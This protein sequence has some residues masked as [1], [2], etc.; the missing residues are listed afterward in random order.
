V[1]IS[2]LIITKDEERNIADCL[3]SLP[4]ADEI[5]VVD[6]GSADRTEEICRR[7]SRVRWFSEPWKGFGPQKNSALDK[8]NNAWVFSIDADERVGPELAKEISTLDLEGA[9]V[10]G[11][12]IPRKSFFGKR[13]VRHG[14]WYPDHTI[15]LWR[16]A[17][18]R[19]ADRSVHEVVRVEG[20]LSTLRGDLL[21][22]TYM[23]TA[24]FVERMNR[25]STL[26]AGELRKQGVRCTLPD[27]LFRPPFTFFRM[28]V[29]RRGF[30]D[31]AL[32]FRL[33]VLYAMY[34][35]LKYAKLRED[36]GR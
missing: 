5:V 4:F 12:R 25:Y 20:A 19:F 30:L 15:R 2:A 27:L 21:H 32:G 18:G 13:W 14:G 24:D 7:D 34:T 3:A 8:A 6:S 29:L 23:D 26:G 31:G 10:A 11:Y 35:F 17:A 16:K 36:D 22:H 9:R 1:K 33:A 28:Y